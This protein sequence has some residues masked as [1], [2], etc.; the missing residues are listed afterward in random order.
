MIN[1]VFITAS[2]IILAVALPYF[3]YSIVAGMRAHKRLGA[4]RLNQQELLDPGAPKYDLAVKPALNLFYLVP[5]L[6]EEA[7]IEATVRHLLL[8]PFV[9]VLVIDDGSEDLT[10]KRAKQAAIDAQAESRLTIL[11][12]RP[13]NARKGKGAALN[14][15]YECIGRYI[16][17]MGFDPASVIIGVM[18]ADGRLSPAAGRPALQCFAEDPK[19]GSV[20]YVVRIRNREKLIGRFQDIE[21]WMISAMSQF[22]RVRSGT[23]S[24]G[25]NGQ[26]TRLSALASLPGEPWTSSLTED[27]DIGLRLVCQGWKATTSVDAYVDQQAVER[28]RPLVRQ[29]IRWYQGH[30]TCMNRMKEV[31]SSPN[32]SQSAV[33]EVTTYLLVP[34]VIVLPWSIIQQWVFYEL[35]FGAGKS[36]LNLH[37][38]SPV[39]EMGYLLFWYVFSFLPNILIGLIYYRRTRSISL[40]KAILMG[41]LMLLWNYIGY[42]SAWAAL[43]RMIK[44]VRSWS[45]TGRTVE[46]E[47][48]TIP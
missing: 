40:P 37:V 14:A 38:G 3:I 45:K 34:W 16:Y 46:L 4:R 10:S 31:W 20:Q 48:S 18:D 17:D 27:L 25:G 1:I 24:L 35:A 33:I 29:R 7:V 9:R 42:I 47:G 41:H 32:V 36:I 11:R 13:P 5:A 19:V 30:M 6:N 22:S 12:R 21:F 2:E 28:Y 26:F 8:D 44:G 39:W 15:G 23:V 43:V